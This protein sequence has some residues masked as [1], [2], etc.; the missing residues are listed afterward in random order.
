MGQKY[1]AL[2]IL[3]F[4]YP[5]VRCLFQIPKITI[6]TQRL[7][8]HAQYL[9]TWPLLEVGS[10]ANAP[11]MPYFSVGITR[12]KNG[13]KNESKRPDIIVPVDLVLYFPNFP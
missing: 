3:D 11:R 13:I 10:N 9:S 7:N 8:V 6:N 12:G 5:L 2:W 4:G 1:W